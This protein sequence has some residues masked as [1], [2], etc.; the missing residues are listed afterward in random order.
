[1]VAAGEAGAA[2]NLRLDDLRLAQ[3]RFQLQ[4]SAHL[5]PGA[6]GIAGPSGSGKTTLLELI[7][8]LRA[9]SS[10]RLVCDG[11]VL[12]DPL[13]GAAV[14]AFERHLGYVPQDADL[15]PHLGVRENLCFG[16]A[17]A[18]GTG[19][20]LE[21]VV[22]MLGLQERLERDPQTL[23]GGERRRVALG[24]AL[25]AGSQLL[26]LDEPFAGL[27]SVARK[28]LRGALKTLRRQL[29]LPMLLVSH[30]SADL[31]DLC[32]KVVKMHDGVLRS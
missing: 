3:G 10:G 31:K 20:S 23:S 32:D 14:P 24:R 16:Q 11:R 9:P 15:F 18:Q 5:E 8:G 19:P 27:D 6:L 13:K 30:E 22:E 28:E 1:M 4:A 29:K 25:L 17:R 21:A 26:L 2:M 7:A 12:D